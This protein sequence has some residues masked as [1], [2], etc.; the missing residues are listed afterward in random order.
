VP[1]G[2][3]EHWNIVCTMASGIT[4]KGTRME[5]QEELNRYV[6]HLREMYREQGFGAVL[7]REQMITRIVPMDEVEDGG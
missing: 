6:G 4:F 2:E 1:N 7:R 3:V 5:A